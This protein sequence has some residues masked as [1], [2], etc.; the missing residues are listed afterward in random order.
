LPSVL[1]ESA[2]VLVDNE[3]T[4]AH[5]LLEDGIIKRV[6]RLRPSNKADLTINAS[7]LIALPGMIDSHV[8]LRDLELAYKE[9]FETGTQAAAA[10]GFTTLLDM[11]NTKPPTTSPTA[12]SEKISS[13]QGR[14]FVN[15]GFQGALVDDAAQLKEMRDAGAIAFK[16]YLNKALETF[17]SSDDEQLGRALKAARQCNVTV[18]VHAEDGTS[19][20]S[21]QERSLAKGRTTIADFLRAHSPQA[22]VSAVRR[23]LGMGKQLGVRTHICHI[24]IAEAVGMVRHTPNATCE[25]TAHH[26]LLNQSIFKKQKTL[27]ICVPPIRSEEYRRQ[28]WRLFRTGAVDI[29]ASDHAPH[30]LEEKTTIDAWKAASGVPG[31]ET[32]L[33]TLFTQV[34]HERL[35]LG[36]LIAATATIP[37][38]I[39]GLRHKGVLA[40]GYD[41]DV[42][43]VDP[44]AK[45]R[46]RPETFLSKAKYS[47][48]K[49]MSCRGKA[50]YT[51]VNGALVVERGVIVGPQA[52]TVI[53]SDR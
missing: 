20:H 26:L 27:A 47:P 32:S 28:L 7:R 18:T 19:I 35:S 30:T 50:A 4:I 6:S 29:L 49:G 48:F 1:I 45:V 12:L 13:A 37:A 14:L 52:G 16:L 9:T 23:I 25:A 3:L 33:T 39:F 51:F 11:P 44:K 43:L 36:R 53:S 31:L 34:S 15:V 41:A 22:E 8:H 5:I 24:T 40:A 21:V 42:V 17:D 2:K 46:I 38:R 10:G